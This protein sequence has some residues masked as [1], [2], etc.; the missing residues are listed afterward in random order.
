MVYRNGNFN[1]SNGD[2]SVMTDMISVKINGKWNIILPEHR[3]NRKEYHEQPYWE[4]ARLNSM[5]EQIGAGD[6]VYYVGAEEGEMPALCQMWGAE[7]VLFEPN[8]RVWPNI[9]SIW[10]SNNLEPPTSFVGFASNISIEGA[11]IYDNWPDCAYGEVIG[12]HGFKELQDPGDIHQIR[13][14]E[15]VNNGAKYPTAVCIDVEGSEKRVLEGMESLMASHLK[16]KIW[17]SIHPE[18]MFRIYGEYQY[19]LRRWIKDLG[20]KETI[21]DYQHELHLMYEPIND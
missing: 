14:S 19:D 8:D 5:H 12:D 16:P 1:Y 9:R 10:E 17:L 11:T 2:I 6:V 3:A 18:F 7:V 13:I 20:Y 4:E 15:I 21:L